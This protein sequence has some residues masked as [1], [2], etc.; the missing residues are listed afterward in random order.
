MIAC[1]EN[2]FNFL[3][4]GHRRTTTP[5]SFKPIFES[6]IWPKGC[7]VL[8]E[9]FQLQV[10]VL[11]FGVELSRVLTRFGAAAQRTVPVR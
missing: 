2:F 10:Q 11:T 8:V 9:V 1:P 7:N 4:H 5:I 3:Y 6:S